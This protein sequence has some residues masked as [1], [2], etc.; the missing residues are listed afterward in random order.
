MVR[1]W[2]SSPKKISDDGKIIGFLSKAR[3]LLKAASEVRIQPLVNTCKWIKHL[4]CNVLGVNFVEGK[5]IINSLFL[6]SVSFLSRGLKRKK[7]AEM[8]TKHGIQF[9]REKLVPVPTIK[10]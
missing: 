5:Q 1:K 2:D 10:T 9:C 4:Q 8:E 6:F 3:I 7:I